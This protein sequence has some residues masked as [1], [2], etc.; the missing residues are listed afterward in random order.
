[1]RSIIL[2][3]F[4]CPEMFSA[5]RWVSSSRH[6]FYSQTPGLL[7]LREFQFCVEIFNSST[8]NS[9][10]FSTRFQVCILLWVG[11]LML[12]RFLTTW[13]VSGTFSY[14]LTLH[15]FI[16]YSCLIS[17]PICLFCIHATFQFC[18]ILKHSFQCY[19][20]LVT[21]Y[22]YILYFFSCIPAEKWIHLK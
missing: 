12:H 20:Y 13:Q 19:C 3:A 8:R 21:S 9:S 10:C 14:F 6:H 2:D 7:L 11:L 4:A 1:M 5:Y 17:E 16:C 18:Y 15:I 22:F